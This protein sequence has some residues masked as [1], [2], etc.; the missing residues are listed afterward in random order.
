MS[1]WIRQPLAILAAHAAGGVVIEDVRI[2]ECVPA[3]AIPD[4]GGRGVRCQ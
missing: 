4:K 2:S 3:G 1:L